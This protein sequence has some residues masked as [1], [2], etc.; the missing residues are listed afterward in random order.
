M[1]CR[2][3]VVVIGGGFA[4]LSCAV[5]LADRGIRVTVLEARRSLGGR[6]T[7]FV[8]D[9]TGEV[10]DNGQH[11]LMACYR[12]TRRFLDALGTSHLVRFQKRLTVD[13]LRGGF[14]ARLKCP[15]L[16]PPWHLVAGVL[17]LKGLDLRDRL[18]LLRAAPAL[19]NVREP[20]AAAALEAMSVSEWLDRLGQTNAL[21]RWLWHP[22][23]I[24]TLNQSPDAAPASLLAAVLREGFMGRAGDS[25][26]GVA[27]VGLGDLYAEPARRHIEQRGGSV[28]TGTP[29]AG[30]AVSG[31]R[32]GA[33]LTRDGEAIPAGAVVIAVAPGAL[34]RLG[35]PGLP[36]RQYDLFESS[37]IVSVNL[38]F[39]RPVSEIAPFDFA[40]VIDGR[41]QWLFNQES[42]LGGR[43]R[44]LSALISASADLVERTSEEIAAMVVSDVRAC[45]PAARDVKITRTMVVKERAA[46]FAATVPTEP[47]RPGPLTPYGNLLLAGDWT[48]RGMPA[49]IEAAVRTGHRCAEIAAGLVGGTA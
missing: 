17:T 41:A 29:A 30:L 1:T 49:T 37:P 27:T 28:R 10:M 11:F 35:V 12:Q 39:D 23:A 2:P 38:W 43:A 16:P 5:A 21:K 22:L 33:V 20:A 34:A 36:A 31:D 13:Y 9:A 4:G 45:L 3:H 14:R 40:A 8:D 47:L 46:T 15:P 32:V 48:E 7:S 18:A 25:C 42:I 44:Y 6:A 26:L 19:R 24:A